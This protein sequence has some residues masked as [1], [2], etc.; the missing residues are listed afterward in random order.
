MPYTASYSY[1]ARKLPLVFS[2]YI[3][4]CVADLVWPVVLEAFIVKNVVARCLLQ[5]NRYVIHHNTMIVTMR[6]TNRDHAH[7]VARVPGNI[8]TDV[9]VVGKNPPEYDDKS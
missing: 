3:V 2:L 9:S 4:R 7:I 1:I 6:L 8:K 5:K